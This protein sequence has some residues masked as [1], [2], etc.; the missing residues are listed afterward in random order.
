MFNINSCDYVQHGKDSNEGC[1]VC[2]GAL[3]LLGSNL[4]EK[5]LFCTSKL[6]E[7]LGVEAGH[8]LMQGR[9]Y[10]WTEHSI[11]TVTA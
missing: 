2:L 10:K 4:V 5:S 1:I 3:H 6:T 9:L 8:N 7:P 11:L